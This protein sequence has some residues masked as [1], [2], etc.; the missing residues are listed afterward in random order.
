MNF[1]QFLLARRHDPNPALAALATLSFTDKRFPWKPKP[2]GRAAREIQREYLIEK[3]RTSTSSAMSSSTMLSA[4]DRVWE[5][6]E[7]MYGKK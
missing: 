7:K 1:R 2:N 4:F 5:E 3:M 6:F